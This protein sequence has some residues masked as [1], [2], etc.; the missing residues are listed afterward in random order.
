MVSVWAADMGFG[1]G[2]RFGIFVV[3]HHIERKNKKVYKIT[4]IYFASCANS[5]VSLTGKT[6]SAM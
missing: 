4:M 3:V 5:F 6:D 1:A 2:F